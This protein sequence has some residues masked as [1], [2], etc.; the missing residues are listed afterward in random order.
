MINLMTFFG[1][2]APTA[3]K[4]TCKTRIHSIN[5]DLCY[6]QTLLGL[7]LSVISQSLLASL[8]DCGVTRN[9]SSGCTIWG[10]ER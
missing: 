10:F 2:P 5:S 8:K 4:A 1:N 6:G 9:L 3:I 7:G